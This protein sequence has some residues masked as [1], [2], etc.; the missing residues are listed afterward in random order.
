MSTDERRRRK[1]LQASSKQQPT[2]PMQLAFLC[3]S[4]F[5]FFS[6]LPFFSLCRR[7]LRDASLPALAVRGERRR[8]SGGGR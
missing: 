5:S 8:Q 1:H 4:F 7:R 6:F 2:A 3:F